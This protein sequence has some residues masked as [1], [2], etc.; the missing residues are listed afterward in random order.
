MCICV[1]CVV[2]VDCGAGI[3]RVSKM[4]LDHCE[5]VE[6]VEPNSAFLAEGETALS[7]YKDR[8]S[9]VCKTLQD[10]DPTENK[11]V[12]WMQWVLK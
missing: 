2:C 3:G 12:F 5:H 6:L 4:L 7:E 9:F 8:C 1:V 11:D 10:Y